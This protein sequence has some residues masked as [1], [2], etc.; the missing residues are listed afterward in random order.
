MESWRK[1][2]EEQK[3]SSRVALKL[4]EIE[5]EIKLDKEILRNLEKSSAFLKKLQLKLERAFT[6]IEELNVIKACGEEQQ[7]ATYDKY[8]D[9]MVKIGSFTT[10]VAD[11]YRDDL[12]F[13]GMFPK[14]GDCIEY[15]FSQQRDRSNW[16][17]SVQPVEGA[18]FYPTREMWFLK[19][20][21]YWSPSNRATGK[22]GKLEN[23]S[24]RAA[25]LEKREGSKGASEKYLN[26]IS[27]DLKKLITRVSPN[28]NYF[29]KVVID[30]AKGNFKPIS[31]ENFENIAIKG[32]DRLDKKV[33][34]SFL[35]KKGMEAMIGEGWYQ[36][37]AN[38]I[39]KGCV[40]AWSIMTGELE[41]NKHSRSIAAFVLINTTDYIFAEMYKVFTDLKSNYYLALKL[42]MDDK[43]ESIFKAIIAR[44]VNEGLT[45]STVILIGKEFQD[46]ESHFRK[47]Y[48]ELTG[49]ISALSNLKLLAVE[50]YR[51]SKLE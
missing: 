1:Y 28:S 25:R 34:S 35:L 26:S 9:W 38:I 17:K 12:T 5:K 27:P 10:A 51:V 48:S 50:V 37:C 8:L 46:L 30:N 2:L 43:V 33:S 13:D 29:G 32:L 36:K 16:G 24:R 6:E 18:V 40:W 45:G 3:S 7:R 20:H 39:K 4:A 15:V 41:A 19:P 49:C 23:L 11:R 22:R 47:K 42:Y 44:L 31:Y 21:P 14:E